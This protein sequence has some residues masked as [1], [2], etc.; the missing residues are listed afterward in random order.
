[1]HNPQIHTLNVVQLREDTPGCDHV[2]HLNNAGAAL[3]PRPV[4][5]AIKAHI[6]LE[7]RIGGYE[8]AAFQES[9]LKAFY[10]N[11]SALINCHPDEIAYIENATRAWDMAF[12]SLRLTA[13]D[14]VL[15]AVSEYAS[16]YLAF[17]HQARHR[18]ILV[19][20]VKND[21][22]GQLDISDLESK[23]DK[24]VKLIAMTHVPTNG[25]LVNPAA[26]VGCIAKSH[27]IPYLLDTTQSI[28]QMPIDVNELHCD[29]LCATG[30][31]YLR[32]PRGTGFL[33][34]S[35]RIIEQCDPPFI[36]LQAAKW[37]ADDKYELKATSQRFE[38]WEQYI[39]GKIALGV[40]IDYA[41]EVGLENSWQRIKELSSY[42]RSSLKA[43]PGVTVHD[44]GQEQCGIVTFTLTNKS[45]QDIQKFLATKRINVSISLLEYA[46]LDME[47]RHLNALV[48]ASIH[49]YNII[50]EI[51]IF[52]TTIEALSLDHG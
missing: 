42:L 33:Y 11:A 14:K 24:S 52:C 50:D 23:I 19:E 41:Q 25:G 10:S 39:A 48:R 2:L 38:T 1:M 12:Y 18:G 37:V 43:I 47:K 22:F 5:E 6:D 30:R 20:V 34:A 32:G 51:D 28:G 17:L 44:L 31:K 36:D 16:N 45:A 13:G 27:H 35:K 46:R 8:A 4:I 15:T 7:A 3:P 40:A 29:F 26:A 9:K 21:E 49:Y